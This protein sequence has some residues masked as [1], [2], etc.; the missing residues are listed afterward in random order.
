[1]QLQKDQLKTS[2]IFSTKIYVR[3]HTIGSRSVG[4]KITYLLK[5]EKPVASIKEEIINIPVV[6]PF[7]ISTKFL[8]MRFGEISKFYVGEPFILMPV[9]SC[10]SQWP[11]TIQDTILEF[12]SF[13]F[14]FLISIFRL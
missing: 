4:I 5:S 3:C 6:K 10:L 9:I 13:L 7:D 8:T 12:V 2:E 11:I 1:M 14:L